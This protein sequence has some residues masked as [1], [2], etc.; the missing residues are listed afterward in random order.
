MLNIFESKKKKRYILEEKIRK[1]RGPEG[2]V[3]H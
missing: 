3:G 1:R 2:R